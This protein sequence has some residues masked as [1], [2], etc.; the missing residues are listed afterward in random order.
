M[1]YRLTHA[2]SLIA[3]NYPSEIL[4]GRLYLGDQFHAAD[5]YILKHLRVTHILNVSNLIPN[6]FENSSNQLHFI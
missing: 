3:K 5:K 1:L 4:Q 6:H 2:F